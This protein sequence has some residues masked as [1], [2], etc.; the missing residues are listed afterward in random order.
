MKRIK[1]NKYPQTKIDKNC[2]I[3]GLI[4]GLKKSPNGFTLR[5]IACHYILKHSQH[6]ILTRS[7]AAKSNTHLPISIS[8]KMLH[9]DNNNNHSFLGVRTST[10][11]P[12][13]QFNSTIN[14][15][16]K[17]TKNLNPLNKHLYSNL[18]QLDPR[19]SHL[20]ATVKTQN[21]QAP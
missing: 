17:I 11:H 20:E 12:N 3:Q 15:C 1:R 10:L 18:N 6:V 9:I 8:C 14:Q 19:S 4:T 7:T 21:S 16:H 2:I 5:F 13:S